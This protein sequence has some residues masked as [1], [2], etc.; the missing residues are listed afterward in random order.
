MP[1]YIPRYH[2]R[3]N[4]WGQ[5]EDITP[6]DFENHFVA[7]GTGNLSFGNPRIRVHGQDSTHYYFGTYPL[8]SNPELYHWVTQDM[9][10][11][12]RPTISSFPQNTVMYEGFLENRYTDPHMYFAVPFAHNP[13]GAFFKWG[14]LRTYESQ[15]LGQNWTLGSETDFRGVL[16]LPNAHINAH[17]IFP[18]SNGLFQVAQVTGSDNQVRLI[19]LKD[20]AVIKN[21]VL[22]PIMGLFGINASSYSAQFEEAMF[23]MAGSSNAPGTGGGQFWKVDANGITQTGGEPVSSPRPQILGLFHN[24]RNSTMLAFTFPL[25]GARI[26]RSFDY[27]QTLEEYGVNQGFRINAIDIINYRRRAVVE[28]LTEFDPVRRLGRTYR[29]HTLTDDL[30]QNPLEIDSIINAIDGGQDRLWQFAYSTK[31]YRRYS[32]MLLQRFIND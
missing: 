3:Q 12:W 27:G 16:G 15:D 31:L 21:Q 7:K 11:T 19:G 1:L 25:A 23:Y 10:G 5:L 14:I 9:G 22:P 26:Y 4:P 18:T 13:A 28:K 17:R 20:N 30:D 6:Y 8:V 29:S 24:P 32:K 2:N